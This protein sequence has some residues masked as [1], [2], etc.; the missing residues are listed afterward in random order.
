MKNTG[1]ARMRVLGYLLTIIVFLGLAPTIAFAA[2]PSAFDMFKVPE[3]SKAKLS[4]SGRYLA[5]VRSK[6]VIVC[7][8]S[9]GK[10][11]PENKQDCKDVWKT[12][13]E[14]NT[15]YIIDL[16]GGENSVRLPIPQDYL[17]DWLEWANEDRLLAS[18]SLISTMNARGTKVSLGGSRIISLG[19]D[20]TD[21]AVMFD[22]QIGMNKANMKLSKIT[23]LLPN[24]PKHVLMPAR[25]G[26]DLDLWKV[27]IETGDVKRIA[28]AKKGT[29]FWY[30][31]RKGK[32]ILRFD[33]NTLGT[34]VYVFAW[35][36]ERQDWEQIKTLKVRLRDGQE[37]FDFYPAAP[38]DI[39]HQIYVVSDED[40]G[41]RRAIK[42]FDF[43]ENRFVRTVFEHAE[44]DVGG[45]F[46]DH[47]SGEYAGVYY[48]DDRLR[49]ALQNPELQK[50]MDALDK[51]F[52]YEVN[53]DL[54]G[55]TEDGTRMILYVSG[56]QE[57]G[58]YHLYDIENRQ[59]NLLLSRRPDLA[60]ANFGKTEILDIPVRDGSTIRGYLTHPGNGKN[61]VAPLIVMP[62]GGPEARDYFDYDPWVQFLATR[63]YQVLQVNFRGSSGYGRD[64][65]KAGYGQWGGLMQDD[66][67]DAVKFLHDNNR[68][69]AERTCI[70][71]YS[72][73]GYAALMGG[74]KT[75]ELYQCIVAGGATSD[76]VW[77]VNKAKDQYGRQSDV[78]AYWLRSKGDP[79]TDKER[80]QANSPALQA[81]RIE[82]P[83]LL[84][85][86]TL[87]EIVPFANSEKMVRALRRA[88]KEHRIV[89][90]K[91]QGH[92][93]WGLGSKI[94]YWR[95]I[96]DFLDEQLK[97]DAITAQGE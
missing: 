52:Q 69:P 18:I 79:K 97:G 11:R 43:K 45:L 76:L 51:F 85:H 22:G 73:G 5:V 66:V 61:P 33:H 92:S 59:L 9:Y 84:F 65:A 68:A 6:I 8:D 40:E 74:I 54:L 56:P 46:L 7:V 20:G 90:L 91:G 58:A 36:D 21:M 15:I 4:P 64:F 86:G 14:K 29:F 27:N 50:H 89:E 80:M 94:I 39:P 28:I 19:R 49:Y 34:K 83:V 71:G 12:Y 48:Y 95:T 87:D 70:Y 38:T 77:S 47:A 81:E 88:K 23:N 2:P 13:R 16:E 93:Y 44:F 10:A 37:V 75:P 62:H 63:G 3:F 1:C 17:I 57:P 60:Q 24:D 31:D 41:P 25:K 67:T 42:I 78:Y 72:Y 96:E 53:I 55:F 82:V 35:S 30:T 32:P 26:G